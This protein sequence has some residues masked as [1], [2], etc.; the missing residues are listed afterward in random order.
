MSPPRGGGATCYR[1]M[2]KLPESVRKKKKKNYCCYKWI[3]PHTITKLCSWDANLSVKTSPLWAVRASHTYLRDTPAFA[4]YS[5]STC[6]LSPITFAALLT[7]FYSS[8]SGFQY[9][10]NHQFLS[11]MGQI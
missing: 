4:S 10:Y 9:G 8:L 5:V 11:D 6:A 7:R 3:P 2:R 1:G